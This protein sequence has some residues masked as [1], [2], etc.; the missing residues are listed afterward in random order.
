MF[1]ITENPEFTHD[2]PVQVPIDDGHR[3]DMLKTRFRAITL[4]ESEKYDLNTK[5]GTTAYLE[6]IVVSFQN[7]ADAEGVP[8]ASTDELRRDLLD[9]SYVRMALTNAY[10]RAMHKA[11]LGN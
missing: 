8:I 7:L 3:E 1:K 2:V 11:R 5:E 9:L 4:S 6:R 10:M